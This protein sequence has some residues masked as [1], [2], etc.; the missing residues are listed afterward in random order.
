VT[1][2]LQQSD[3]QGHAHAG[4]DAQ[5][6]I[7][8][9][10]LAVAGAAAARQKRFPR[11]LPTGHADDFRQVCCMCQNHIIAAW[12]AHVAANNCLRTTSHLSPARRTVTPPHAA[13]VQMHYSEEHE[14]EE[15]DEECCMCQNHIIAAWHAHMAANNCLRTTSHLSPARRTVTPPHAAPVQVHYSEEHEEEENDEEGL[16]NLGEGTEE[17]EEVDEWEDWGGYEGDE[18]EEGQ[19]GQEDEEGEEGEEGDEGDEG[20]GDEGEEGD[21]C[22]PSEAELAR[23]ARF[24]GWSAA[25]GPRRAAERNNP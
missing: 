3:Q 19:E 4:F 2:K 7:A 9:A 11:S 24:K 20:E 25:A 6:T 22:Q 10:S 16:P 5:L 14:E 12:H 17:E 1:G 8:R 21:V 15:N 23:R 13:P 18:G